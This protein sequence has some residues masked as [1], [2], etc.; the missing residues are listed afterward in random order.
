M[1][2]ATG[3]AKVINMKSEEEDK[4]DNNKTNFR[5]VKAVN[6][7][8]YKGIL[9]ACSENI[10]YCISFPKK[11]FSPLKNIP[12]NQ[13]V[14]TPVGKRLVNA[15]KYFTQHKFYPTNCSILLGRQYNTFYSLVFTLSIFK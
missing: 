5:L 14:L 3:I 2:V 13:P 6:C 12:K 9:W 8:H 4:T 10:Y 11:H 15:Y 7:L 1:K